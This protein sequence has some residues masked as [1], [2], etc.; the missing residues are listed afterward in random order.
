MLK[1]CRLDE[2]IQMYMRNLRLCRRH[3]SSSTEHAKEAGINSWQRPCGQHTDINIYN[4]TMRGKVPLVLTNPQ[5]VTWY[6]CGPTVYDSTHLGHASTYVKVDIIQ[7]ILRDYFKLNLV[8]AMNITDVDDKIIKR[9]RET[10]RNWLE[11]TRGFDEEFKQDMQLLNVKPPNLRAN[12]SS[13]IPSIQQFVEKL[14]VDQKAYVTEDKSVYFDVSSCVNYGKLQN[15]C[16]DE[17][18]EQHKYKRNAADF[19]LWKAKKETDEPSWQSSWGGEGRP[20][21]HIECSAIAG[22]FFGNKLDFH[23]GGLD[24]RFPHH[25]NEE[26]QCCAHYKI[27]QW[28]NYWVHTGQLYIAG[29]QEKMSKSLGNTISL[30]EFLKHY[31]ADEFRMA[32]LLSNYRNSMHYSDQLMQTARQTLRKFLNFQADLNAYMQ[33]QKPLKF[34][35][36]G[37]LQAQLKHMIIEFDNSLRDDFDTARAITVLLDQMSSISR[38]INDQ[39]ADAEQEPAHCLHLLL[40]A[41]NF[42]SASMHNFGI[43][44]LGV[45]VAQEQEQPVSG[46]SGV[47]IDALVAEILEIRGKLRE[48]AV[49]ADRKNLELLR[50]CDQLR[51]LLDRHG[52]EVRDHKQGSSWVYRDKSKSISTSG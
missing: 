6:T 42:I 47:V 11:L 13:K 32:C 16:K 3:L 17:Q 1:I 10:G 44:H 7:R 49:K 24:L 26:A 20:G 19:A 9:S 48:E 33:F 21:W 39:Q 36:E 15:I 14:L 43:R 40:A 22:M 29:E 5:M 27:D 45:S 51:D 38:C 12:V 30:S 34:L 50:V 37:A 35:D 18:K 2:C 8:T 23:A 46:S 25:E 4:H 41:G 52:I 31:S 28:V